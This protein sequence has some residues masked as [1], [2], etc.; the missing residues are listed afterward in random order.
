MHRCDPIFL[1]YQQTLWSIFLS[2][3]TWQLTH[4]PLVP[5]IFVSELSPH[6]FRQWLVA[7]S[8]P[9]H[10]LNQYCVIVNWTLRNKLQ[11]NCYQNTKPFTHENA[12]ENI[13]CERAAILSR[14]RWVKKGLFSWQCGMSVPLPRTRLFQMKPCPQLYISYNWIVLNIWFKI[15]AFLK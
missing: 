10:Y 12:S 5:H 9:S 6:W 7:Y 13:V 4:L 2:L 15:C 11:W 1:F 8:A 3:I 14:E